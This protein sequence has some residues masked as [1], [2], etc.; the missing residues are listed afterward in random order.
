M[1]NS[2]NANASRKASYA[3]GRCW[4]SGRILANA[5]RNECT[6]VGRGFLSDWKVLTKW[7]NFIECSIERMDPEVAD[8]APPFSSN[9]EP[10]AK[11]PPGFRRGGLVGQKATNKKVDV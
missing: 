11:R 7:K 10:A 8:I 3:S 9:I 5:Q 2:T 1:L 6:S 4:Q